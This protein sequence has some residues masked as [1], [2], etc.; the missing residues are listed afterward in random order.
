MY[1]KNSNKPK[2]YKQKNAGYIQGVL[3]NFSVKYFVFLSPTWK[4]KAWNTQNSRV[5]CFP[6]WTQYWIPHF[7]GNT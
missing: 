5:S 6:V 2:L 1:L 3:A 7:M 4:R